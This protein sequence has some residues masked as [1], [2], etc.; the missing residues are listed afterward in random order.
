MRREG[1]SAEQVLCRWLGLDPP[2]GRNG[3]G[4]TRTLPERAALDGLTS[5]GAAMT[6]AQITAAAAITTAATGKGLWDSKRGLC[7]AGGGIDDGG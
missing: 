1:E 5:T 4:S 6:A 3:T 7:L 2:T